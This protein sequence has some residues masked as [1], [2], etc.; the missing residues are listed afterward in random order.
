[1]ILVIIALRIPHQHPD[2]CLSTDFFTGMLFSS[3]AL[4]FFEMVL[5]LTIEHPGFVER[6]SISILSTVF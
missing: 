2:G 1:L 6:E 3:T 4:V 5:N